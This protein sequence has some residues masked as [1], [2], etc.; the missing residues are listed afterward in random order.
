MT[1][2]SML[3]MFFCVLLDHE[4]AINNKIKFAPFEIKLKF[5]YEVP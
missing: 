5:S 2:S 4:E 1:A 3:K